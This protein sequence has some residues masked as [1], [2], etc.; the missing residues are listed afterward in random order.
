VEGVGSN[1][2]EALGHVA[3]IGR[4]R[5]MNASDVKVFETQIIEKEL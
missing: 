1:Q 2:L 5:E 4:P 3:N